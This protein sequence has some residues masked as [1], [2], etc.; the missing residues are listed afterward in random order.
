M[1]FEAL[2]VNV[3]QRARKENIFFTP[4]K[5]QKEKGLQLVQKHL[6]KQATFLYLF[7]NHIHISNL[8]LHR[9]YRRL[10]NK[11]ETIL[12]K[13]SVWRAHLNNFFF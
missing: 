11:N 4:I 1:F 6:Q 3:E 12:S 5:T 13:P 7:K 8:Q 10:E 2:R 9:L